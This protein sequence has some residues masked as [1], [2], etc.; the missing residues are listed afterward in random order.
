MKL[1]VNVKGGGLK[2]NRETAGLSQQALADKNGVRVRA[3][4]SYEQGSKNLNNAKLVTLLK[5]CNALDCTL[6][7][8]ITDDVTM[9]ELEKYEERW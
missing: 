1:I 7:S 5:I 8:I 2:A 9:E 3:I 4:Q 6:S